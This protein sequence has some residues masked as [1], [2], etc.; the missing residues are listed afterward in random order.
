MILQYTMVKLI[1]EGRKKFGFASKANYGSIS[2]AKNQITES[3]WCKNAL[4]SQKNKDFW[5]E[6]EN[7]NRISKN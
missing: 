3:K 1:R 2:D 7:F 6:N 5:N 4:K